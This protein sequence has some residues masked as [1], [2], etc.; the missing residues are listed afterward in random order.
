MGFTANISTNCETIIAAAESAWGKFQKTRSEPAVELRLAVSESL[1]G[2]RPPVRM[3]RG[4][5]HLVSFIHDAENFAICDLRAGFGYGWLTDAVACDES[6]V[7]YHFVEN[8]VLI[9]LAGLYMTPVHAACVSLSGQGVLLCGNSGAGKTTLAYA[10]AKR[11]WTYACDDSAHLIRGS[12]DRIIVANPYQIRFR[13]HAMSLFPELAGNLPFERPN[14]KPSIEL[15]TAP[16][17]LATARETAVDYLVFLNRTTTDWQRLSKYDRDAAYASLSQVVCYGDESLRDEMRSS[18][19]R[20]LTA[21]VFELYYHDL[22]WAEQRL[23]SLVENG[24]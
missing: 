17:H 4:Q 8:C 1:T 9:L 3:P 23:R 19:D 13:A 5:G 18:L 10:C 16:L 21:P 14:G 7:R 6:Y 2:E 24:E 11:G 15:D 22:T 12:E 20:L